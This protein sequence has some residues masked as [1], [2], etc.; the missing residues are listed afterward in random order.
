MAAIAASRSFTNNAYVASRLIARRFASATTST[1]QTWNS[2]EQ[3]TCSHQPS[4]RQTTFADAGQTPMTSGKRR[5]PSG[6]DRV[7]SSTSALGSFGPAAASRQSR[8][9]SGFADRGTTQTPLSKFH[10]SAMR[11]TETWCMFAVVQRTWSSASRPRPEARGPHATTAILR[12][13]HQATNA[14]LGKR[15]CASTWFTA[16]G[17]LAVSINASSCAASKFD[18]PMLR[19]LPSLTS[20]SIAA[21]VSAK[22][23]APSRAKS[24]PGLY[25]R[26][27]WIRSRST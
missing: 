20:A 13:R 8:T 27:Q 19:T 18:T 15:G 21:H 25:L 12:E 22:S 17:I 26:G 24:V 3:R 9:C 1:E 7:N 6:R 11:G 23:C 10:R 14:E 4:S 5:R 16:G 2:T